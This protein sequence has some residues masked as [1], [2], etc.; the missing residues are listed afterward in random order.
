MNLYV[1][2]V[3]TEKPM[4]IGQKFVFDDNNH[5]GVYNRV[6]TCKKIIDRVLKRQGSIGVWILKMTILL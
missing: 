5:N 3:V 2:H 4:I 1:Y 6:I